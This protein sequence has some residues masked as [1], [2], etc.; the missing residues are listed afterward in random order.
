MGTLELYTDNQELQNFGRHCLSI[1]KSDTNI[2]CTPPGAKFVC[3]LAKVNL[4]REISIDHTAQ[5]QVTQQ[6]LNK[7]C[8]EYKDIFSLH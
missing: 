6:T 7:L 5:I 3:S 1:E 8:E 2:P 4:D